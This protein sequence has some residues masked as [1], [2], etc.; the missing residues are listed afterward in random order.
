MRWCALTAA[1]PGRCTWS[2]TRTRRTTDAGPGT[3]T[4]CLALDSGSIPARSSNGGRG[5][6]YIVATARAIRSTRQRR[7]LQAAARRLCDPPQ[8]P[9]AATGLVPLELPPTPAQ[10]HSPDAPLRRAARPPR[11]H[12]G[13]QRQAPLLTDYL[14]ATPTPTAAG[15]LAAHHRRPHPRRGQ[16][17]DAARAVTEARVD[18]ELFALSYDFVG[19]LAE[20]IA[21]IWPAPP[22]PAATTRPSPRSSTRLRAASRREAPQAGRAPAR[23]PRRLR[24]LRAPQAGHRRPARRRLR[25]PRQAGPRRLRRAATSPR[26]RSSGTASTPPYVALF[27]WLDRHAARARRRRRHARFRPV[28]L[29]HALESRRPRPARPRRLSPPNGNGT[30]SASRPPPTPHG[31]RL[32]SRTGDD[33]CGA[34]PDLA[35]RPRLRRRPRRRAAGPPRRRRR[36]PPS[37]TCSSG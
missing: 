15:A 21:L 31:R 37:P 2:A 17:G 5:R 20:T 35:R 7:R 33:I 13:P 4:T 36:S 3:P 23:P 6:P 10:A 24:P 19:D 9:Q 27:A 18:P 29:S 1:R 8:L 34:F 28:M 30:A 26:S 25:P 16:A 22:A 32:Y 14:R 12:P 11:L